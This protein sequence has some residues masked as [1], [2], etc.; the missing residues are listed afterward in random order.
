M[1][2]FRF[3]K[4]YSASPVFGRGLILQ[5]TSFDSVKQSPILYFSQFPWE[6]SALSLAVETLLGS[7]PVEE[8]GRKG[9]AT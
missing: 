3:F 5:V 7:A 8:K 1:W 9:S 6:T 2:E 4:W